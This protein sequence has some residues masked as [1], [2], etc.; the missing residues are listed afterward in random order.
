MFT[1][2]LRVWNLSKNFGNLAALQA[3]D[4]RINAGEVVGLAGSSGAGKSLFIRILAGLQAP[5][6]GRMLFDRQL[7]HWPFQAQRVGIGVIHQEPELAD[8][9]DVT[10]N[11]FL[12]QEVNHTLLGR[13]LPIP[14]Q[15]KMEEETLRLLDAMNVHLPSLHV[16]VGNLSSEQRQLVAIAQVIAQPAKLRIV[17]DPNFL[18][19][20]H[21]EMLLD[22]IR[23]WQKRN[24]AVLFSSANL[25]HLFAV[26]DRIVVLR[27]GWLVAD[28]RS[29]ETNR[30]EIVAALVGTAD[31]QQ[32]TP[33]IWA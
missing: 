28:L 27:E 13:R 9:F 4:L 31:R 1:P 14:N 25:D 33:V 29:D 16:K 6:A 21:Q 10:D 3:V 8:Q 11:V 7:M 20:P 19:L 2:L 5:D 12:G 32:R 24:T 18:S 30:E 15:R 26:A 22:Q 23:D 17:D